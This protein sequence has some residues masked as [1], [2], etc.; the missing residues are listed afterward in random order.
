MPKWSHVAIPA[1]V[2]DRIEEIIKER[3]DLGY[4]SVSAFL[5]DA[6]RRRIE[7][8]EGQDQREKAH[9][10]REASVRKER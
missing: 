1:D 5:L 9:Q 2:A 7:Q 10:H 6:A 4:L 8:L 3:P